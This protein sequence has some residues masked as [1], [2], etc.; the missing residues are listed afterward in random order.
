MSDLIKNRV[1][2]SGLITVDLADFLPDEFPVLF[3]VAAFLYKGLILKEKE[4]RQALSETDW[5]LYEG[6]EVLI[7]CSTDAIIP[8]WAYM[9]A[10]ANL[11]HVSSTLYF[12]KP[13][14][15]RESYLLKNIN[16]INI[17]EFKDAR[18]VLKGCGEEKIP[19]AAYFELT[20][21]LLPVVKSILYGEPCST[22]P[23]YKKKI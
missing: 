18:V 5:S 15:W 2:D 21:R 10:A 19:E 14:Q 1:T 11:G 13:E 16:K 7:Y 4:Y 23:V 20:K 17:N 3:D 9:L 22:V 6:K 8:V 12:M